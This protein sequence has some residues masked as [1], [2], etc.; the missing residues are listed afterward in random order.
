MS[1]RS[2]SVRRKKPSKLKSFALIVASVLAVGIVGGV[3]ANYVNNNHNPFTLD[4]TSKK[5]VGFTG[6]TNS[7]GVLTYTGDFAQYNN[8]TDNDGKEV[9]TVYTLTATSTYVEMSSPLDNEW[10]Y[11]QIKTVKDKYNNSFTAFPVMYMSYSYNA[12]GYLDG[13]S[14]ANYKVDSSYFISDA[15]LNQD[16]SGKYNDYFYIGQFEGSTKDSKLASVASATPTVN[17]TREESRTLARAYGKSSN[18]YNGY[19]QMDITMWNMYGLLTSMYLKTSDVQSVYAGPT[20][21]SAAVLTGTTSP[22]A[23]LNG[24]NTSTHAVKFLGIENAYGSVWEWCDGITFAGTSIYYT[25]NPNNYSDKHDDTV[26]VVVEFD[27]PTTSGY[28]ELLKTGTSSAT[29]S[30]ILSAYTV[31]ASTGEYEDDGYWY[32]Q[33]GT[34][35]CVGGYWNDGSEAGLWCFYGNYAASSSSAHVGARLCGRSLSGVA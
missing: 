7:S 13:V 34:V 5:V 4:G 31:S 28:V 2:R 27:R 10:P 15:Y 23:G 30:V 9:D 18:Y 3:A 19:Q 11:S 22:I 21:L 17:V 35:L 24:W 12:A 32:N 20:D 16:G 8:L 26:D 6:L 1:Q 33:D 25:S 14:F 29:Q